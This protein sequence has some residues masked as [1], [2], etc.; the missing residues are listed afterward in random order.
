MSGHYLHCSRLV[1]LGLGLIPL[2]R[3]DHWPDQAGPALNHLGLEEIFRRHW[4]LRVYVIHVDTFKYYVYTTKTINIKP[5]TKKTKQ[6]VCGVWSKHSHHTCRLQN[7]PSK[8]HI[9]QPEIQTSNNSLRWPW[10]PKHLLNAIDGAL[11]SK[12]FHNCLKIS[13]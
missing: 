3:P 8:H 6:C 11:M 5:K 7:D 1:F 10:L 9:L 12:A 2:K 4:I 13:K